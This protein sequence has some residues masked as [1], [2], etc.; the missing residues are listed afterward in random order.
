MQTNKLKL[1]KLNNFKI[2]IFDLDDTLISISKY[3]KLVFK[4]ICDDLIK[5]NTQKKKIFDKLKFLR[6]KELK[7]LR[8]INIFD[9]IFH[10]KNSKLAVKIYNSYFPNFFKIKKSNLIILKNLKKKKKKLYLVTNGNKKRQTN[11]IKKLGILKYFDK[12]YVLDGNKRKFKPS[13]YSLSPLK[14]I[15][16]YKKTVMIGDSKID[17]QFA[18][19]LK[20]KYIKYRTS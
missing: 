13:T 7:I 17:E 6:K 15:I 10:N 18:K 9:K 12:V 16:K 4:K 14:K 11:K 20:V 3:D 19:N 2:I 5:D 1:N 8:K